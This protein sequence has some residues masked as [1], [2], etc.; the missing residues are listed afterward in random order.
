[1]NVLVLNPGGNSLKVEMVVAN[2][3][4]THAYEAKKLAS[5]SVE[6][7]GKDAKFLVYAGKKIVHSESVEA[8][9]DAQALKEILARLERPNSGDGV[10]LRSTERI[11]VRVVHGG[12]DLTEP[13]Q[14]TPDVERQI[15]ALEKLAPL[16]NKSSVEVLAPARRL[17]KGVPIY[18]VFDTAFH[19]TIPDYA[20]TYAI[21]I[22]LRLSWHLAPLHAGT[23]RSSGRR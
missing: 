5:V 22:E 3:T 2:A 7:I 12:P 15:V 1:L 21:P 8:S 13:T 16:H 23:L 6:D 17:L 14:I 4:Q 11:G 20:S 19:R 10:D 18:G 9:D